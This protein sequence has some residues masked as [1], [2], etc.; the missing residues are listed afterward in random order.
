MSADHLQEKIKA[1][2]KILQRYVHRVWY[3]PL[4]GL[5]A[6]L[7]NILVF[8][9]SDGILISSSMLIPRR[10]FILAFSV[11]L[12]S[13]LG[14]LGLA[15]LVEHHGLPWILEFFP[16]LN[17]SRSWAWTL[18]FFDKYG[19]LLVFAVAVTPF[20]Q[21]PAVILATLADTPLLELAA[22]IFAGR[23]IKF[24][25]MAYIGSHAPRLLT[26]VWGLKKELAATG[27]P[28]PPSP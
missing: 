24:L 22:V 10:W 18:E 14:A 23:F 15:A 7:D 3:P 2:V 8:I 16:G 6:A 28:T 26:K 9:P 11:A 25:L 4:I 17:D 12:G 21:Q 1:Y 19:L 13:A 5:L 20:V 27:E